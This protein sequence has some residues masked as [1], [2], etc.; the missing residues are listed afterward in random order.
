M[1]VSDRIN[2]IA[3]NAN[4]NNNGAREMKLGS[5]DSG[6]DGEHNYVG[7]V[8]ISNNICETGA[9]FIERLTFDSAYLWRW[10]GDTEDVT[11]DW[12]GPHT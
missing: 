1:R 9:F 2:G 12:T 10:S 3:K 7:F 5:D 4:F 11:E 8:W 6:V